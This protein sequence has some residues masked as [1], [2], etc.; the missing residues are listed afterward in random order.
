MITRAALIWLVLLAIAVVNG[1]VRESVLVSWL[2]RGLAQA[3]STVMLSACIFGIGWLATPWIA[4]RSTEGAWVVG[5]SWVTLTLAFEFLG[6][7]FLFAK[8]WTE[9]LADYNLLAGRIWVLVLV[10]TLVTPVVVFTKRI[11]AGVPPA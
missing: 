1:G 4:P 3:I 6:G 9:L 10:I 2:G 8:P 11:A 7:H 5:L